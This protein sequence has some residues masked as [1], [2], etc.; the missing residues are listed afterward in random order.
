MQNLK[1]KIENYELEVP[2][3]KKNGKSW[4]ALRPICE[5]LGVEI[6]GDNKRELWN[7]NLSTGVICPRLPEM[8][9]LERCFV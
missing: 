4:V 1:L 7:Q 6:Q 2:V 9:N 3:F 8:G 5:I